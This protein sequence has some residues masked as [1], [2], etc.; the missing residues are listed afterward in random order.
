MLLKELAPR[1]YPKWLA[2]RGKQFNSE[3]L[4]EWEPEIAACK[5]PA[6][7]LACIAVS[8]SWAGVA[9]WSRT[10]RDIVVRSL[11]T[12][13]VPPANDLDPFRR[14]FGNLLD[15]VLHAWIQLL[16]SDSKIPL[17]ARSSNASVVDSQHRARKA[18][19]KLRNQ[20]KIAGLGAWLL[21]GPYKVF[22]ALDRGRWKSAE[23]S[24]LLMPLGSQVNKGFRLIQKLDATVP[25]AL[26][27]DEEDTDFSV[28]ISRVE[29]AHR[30]E[31][32]WAEKAGSA[33]IHINS[34]LYH[35]GSEGNPGCR[36]S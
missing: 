34:G 24:T 29:F 1:T 22:M 10:F 3:L 8:L 32:K 25:A 31:M 2:D 23:A 17:D 26:F 15:D 16:T 5:G 4:E 19:E 30:Y 7:F 33:A 13:T 12:G 9:V 6:R 21:P 35:L 27:S 18:T 36:P 11:A 14:Q 20:G 28:A